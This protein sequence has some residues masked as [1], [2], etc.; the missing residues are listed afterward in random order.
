MH[1]E[2]ARVLGPDVAARFGFSFPIRFDYLD[3]LDG[4]HLSLQCHPTRAYAR[5]IFG[6]DYTQDE[7]Y[8]VMETTP[9]ASVF[10]GLR[11]DADLAAFRAA[12]ERAEQGVELDAES[13]LLAHAAE[14]HRL[15]LIPAG[16]PHASGAGNV[17]LEISATPYLY[18][19]RFYDWLRRDLGGRLR[20]VHV[21]HA[22]ANV[23]G[24]GAEPRSRS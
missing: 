19:L 6:L 10:L 9:G 14:Q 11:H 21:R 3:T 7:T 20:P 12:A 1:L 13:F 15:Y 22:F 16:T 18:T 4:G 8:Y 23:D 17:V 2:G 5:V 24:G